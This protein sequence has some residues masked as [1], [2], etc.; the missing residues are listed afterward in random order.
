MKTYVIN[1][2]DRK[3]R[4]ELFESQKTVG[5]PNYG[6]IGKSLNSLEYERFDAVNGSKLTYNN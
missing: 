2:S 4:M 5:T 3:D 6:Y 1:L